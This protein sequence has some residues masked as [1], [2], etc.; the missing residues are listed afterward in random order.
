M[1]P[2]KLAHLR[3]IASLGGKARA[4]KLTPERRKEIARQ[5]FAA[6]VAR[7]FGGDKAAA[8]EWLTA[9]LNFVHD[10]CPWN[11][12]FQDPGPMPPARAPEPEPPP[13]AQEDRHEHEEP[14][15]EADELPF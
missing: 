4:A 7:H 2:E 3:A 8:I 6:M 12:V 9:R 15:E 5:G 1:T 14:Q 13:P 10:P 11:R